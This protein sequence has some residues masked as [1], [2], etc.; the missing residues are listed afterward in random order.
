[1]FKLNLPTGAILEVTLPE[2]GTTMLVHRGGGEFISTH[3]IRALAGASPIAIPEGVSNEV[4]GEP[5]HW[6]TDAGQHLTHPMVYLFDV[7]SAYAEA[8]EAALKGDA[9]A[10][11][12]LMGAAR[13]VTP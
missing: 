11:S 3:A 8:R 4:A 13:G 2:G 1:M 6:E 12:L 9:V 7:A 10:T 5:L